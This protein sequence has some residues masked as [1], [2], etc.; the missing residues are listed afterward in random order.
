MA[1]SVHCTIGSDDQG[2]R[3][4]L[5]PTAYSDEEAERFLVALRANPLTVKVEFHH[6]RL[7]PNKYVQ[8]FIPVPANKQDEV[9][10]IV[11]DLAGVELVF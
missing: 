5:I 11:R 1:A 4:Y 9:D 6:R 8:L 2:R 3:S 10:G 7:G